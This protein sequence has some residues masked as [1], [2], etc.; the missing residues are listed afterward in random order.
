MPGRSSQGKPEAYY[1]PPQLNNHAG[2]FPHTYFGF[3]PDVTKDEVKAR[4]AM[5]EVGDNKI[6]EL[7]R[8]YR[9][10]LGTGWYVPP[11]VIHR[12]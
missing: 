3:D 6:T 12:C 2:E 7:S 5:Y 11:G 10:E 8:A 1:Y 4:L 9:I